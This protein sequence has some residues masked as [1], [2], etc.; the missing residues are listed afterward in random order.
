[1]K[2][3]RMETARHRYNH[4]R[5]IIPLEQHGVWMHFGIIASYSIFATFHQKIVSTK[6]VSTKTSFHQKVLPSTFFT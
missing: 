1:M 5:N 6:I 2:R 3:R 4:G